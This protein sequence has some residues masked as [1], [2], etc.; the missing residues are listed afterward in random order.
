MKKILSTFIPGALGF[1]LSGGNKIIAG[2][3]A[4]TSVFY[5]LTTL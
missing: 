5:F 2:A 3:S 4:L 1:A